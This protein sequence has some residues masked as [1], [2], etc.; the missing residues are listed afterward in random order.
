MRFFMVY[1]F[2]VSGILAAGWSLATLKDGPKVHCTW[3]RCP[4]FKR[5]T[6]SANLIRDL[7][8]KKPKKRA[9]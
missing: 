8:K 4:Y 6:L 3:K 7:F 1:F 9:S 5:P 2:A